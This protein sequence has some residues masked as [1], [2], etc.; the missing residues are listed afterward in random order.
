MVA[1]LARALNDH[2]S[3]VCTE[4]PTRF[5]GLATVPLQDVEASVEELKGAKYTLGL[6]GVEIGTTIGEM[7]L[8][9]PRLD[10]FWAACQELDMPVFVHLLAVED[11]GKHAADSLVSIGGGSTIGLGKAISLRTGLPHVCIPTTYAG[12]EMTPLLGETVDGEKITRKDPK[13]LPEVVIYDVDLTMTLPVGLS[14]TSGVNAIAHA[15]EALYSKS[16]NLI[17]DLIAP[18]GVRALVSSLPKIADP[19]RAGAAR[20]LALYGAWLCVF[21]GS[22]GDAVQGLDMVISQLGVTRSLKDLGM[23]EQDIDR[24][25]EVAMSNP[26]WNPRPLERNAVRELIRRAW[27]GEPARADP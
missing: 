7:S 12:S 17:S 27:A 8:D 19:K 9:D 16:R 10:P 18:E 13:I 5:V 15:V 11:I 26:Y 23:K 24:A 3:Q 4:Y 25:V 6:K 14:M 20:E 1:Q 2:P 22:K 21:L